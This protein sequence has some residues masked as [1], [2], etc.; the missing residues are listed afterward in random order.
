MSTYVIPHARAIARALLVTTAILLAGPAAHADTVSKKVR[1]DAGETVP[2]K[3]VAEGIEIDSLRFSVEGGLKLNPFKTGKGPQAFLTVKNTGNKSLD[4]AIAVALY[5]E[6]GALIAAS[7]SN[8]LGDLEPGEDGE[9]EVMFRYVKRK[10]YSAKT[11]EVVLDAPA[12]QLSR[13]CPGR[14]SPPHTTSRPVWRSCVW[15][16]LRRTACGLR[17]PKAD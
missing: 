16:R 2:V 7:E 12:E 17:R 5:D 15:V 3:L 14:Q 10:V 11:V 4:F 9:I 8:H 6:K 13:S 1:F